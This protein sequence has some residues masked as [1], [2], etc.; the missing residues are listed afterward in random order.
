[1]LGQEGLFEDVCS[2]MLFFLSSSGLCQYI[3]GITISDC[4]IAKIF[5]SLLSCEQAKGKNSH[6]FQQERAEMRARCLMGATR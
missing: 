6:G 3:M 1:M 4:L 5:G 2:P